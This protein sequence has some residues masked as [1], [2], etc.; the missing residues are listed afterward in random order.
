MADSVRVVV[1]AKMLGAMQ[2]YFVVHYANLVQEMD[3]ILFLGTVPNSQRKHWSSAPRRF[4]FPFPI[5][6][7]LPISYS[8]RVVPLNV[9]QFVFWSK[10][11][12]NAVIIDSAS[13]IRTI[14]ISLNLKVVSFAYLCFLLH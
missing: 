6:T 11:D 4:P 10:K 3:V 12:H 14:L 8:G 2:P 5:A 9:A 7:G 1:A 13:Q